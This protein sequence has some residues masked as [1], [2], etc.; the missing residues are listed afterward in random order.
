NGNHSPF[1]RAFLDEI[2]RPGH[3]LQQSLSEIG[4]LVGEATDF[5][6][7]PWSR[8]SLTSLLFMNGRVESS[9]ITDVSTAI[10]NR[11]Y[12]RLLAGDKQGA[13]VEALKAFPSTL[14]V[15]TYPLFETANGFLGAIIGSDYIKVEE[16][17]PGLR[18]N[19]VAASLD[20]KRFA[21]VLEDAAG[22]GKPAELQ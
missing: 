16:A 2:G 9:D 4:R 19:S 6:Q 8:S 13:M 7:T 21:L 14:D 18:V 3:S 12:Q 15:A 20:G 10:L 5:S 22:S 11:A 1:T 17:V